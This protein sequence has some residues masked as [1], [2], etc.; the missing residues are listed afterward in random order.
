MLWILIFLGCSVMFI[1]LWAMIAGIVPD[2]PDDWD[3]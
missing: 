1:I 3:L 2:E